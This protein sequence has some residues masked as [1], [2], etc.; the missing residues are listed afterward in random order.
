MIPL[1]LQAAST[2]A[3]SAKTKTENGFNADSQRHAWKREMERA[4]SEAWF[5]TQPA[6]HATRQQPPSMARHMAIHGLDVTSAGLNSDSAG[7]PGNEGLHILVAETDT[8][9]NTT[10]ASLILSPVPV[11]AG[12]NE[13]RSAPP[14]STAVNHQQAPLFIRTADGSHLQPQSI[15]APR[16]AMTKGSTQHSPVR[17]HA[18]WNGNEVSIWLGID[19]NQSAQATQLIE[20]LHT[21]LQSQGLRPVTIVCNGQLA[22]RAD[23]ATTSTHANR[24]A[25]ASQPESAD[26]SFHI[27]ATRE[28]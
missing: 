22:Y 26:H 1:I 20:T 14:L 2:P 28:T 13:P 9:E 27:I 10:Q 8:S 4:Q 7:V 24:N 21:W 11:T 16:M 12:G 15:A 23:H 5:K 19:A 3:N 17:M 18:Q 6:T 25:P